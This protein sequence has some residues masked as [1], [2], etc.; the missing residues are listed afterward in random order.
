MG[1]SSPEREWSFYKSCLESDGRIA[2]FACEFLWYCLSVTSKSCMGCFEMVPVLGCLHI[3]ESHK[4]ILVSL[5][6]S[7]LAE[8]RTMWSGILVPTA[9]PAGECVQ[10]QM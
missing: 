10:G 6:M 1:V 9:L 4:S 3:C 8:L 5:W 2:V 7:P